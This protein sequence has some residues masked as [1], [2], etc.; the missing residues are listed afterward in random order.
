MFES[1][2]TDISL[3]YL[4]SANV[5]LALLSL[6]KFSFDAILFYI[7]LARFYVL[8]AFGKSILSTKKVVNFVEKKLPL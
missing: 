1:E 5:F 7:V 8:G 4:V 6:D 2:S 3:N